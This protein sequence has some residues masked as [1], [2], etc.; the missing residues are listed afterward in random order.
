MAV[1]TFPNLADVDY[2]LKGPM[3]MVHVLDRG[4]RDPHQ[5]FDV[6][7]SEDRRLE[8]AT[9]R[10]RT[11]AVLDLLIQ[12]FSRVSQQEKAHFHDLISS[13]SPVAAGGLFGR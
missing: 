11:V 10:A 5:L 4:V 7:P 12:R 13:A 1:N 9:C 6:V 8:S 3:N 2:V